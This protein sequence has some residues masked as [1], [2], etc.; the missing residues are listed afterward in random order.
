MYTKKYRQ[1]E[2]QAKSIRRARPVNKE[3]LTQLAWN[4]GR[5]RKCASKRKTE[6]T[7]IHRVSL[8]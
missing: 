8:T 1:R 6:I 2:T 7:L 5:L 4:T 3:K